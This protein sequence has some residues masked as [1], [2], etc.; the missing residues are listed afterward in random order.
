M[1]DSQS[2]APG[3]SGPNRAGQGRSEETSM[4]WRRV[5]EPFTR[6]LFFAWSRMTRG[7]TLGSLFLLD[8][9]LGWIEKRNGEKVER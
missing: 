7:K 6:P 9:V 4:N 2:Q 8:S 3:I 5:V 1:R